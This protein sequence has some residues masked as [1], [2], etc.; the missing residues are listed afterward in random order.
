MR[1]NAHALRIGAMRR[2]PQ[3]GVSRGDRAIVGVHC[4]LAAELLSFE[5]NK[6]MMIRLRCCASCLAMGWLISEPTAASE[7]RSGVDWPQFRGVNACGVSDGAK[8]PT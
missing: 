3:L 1:N 8:S 2:L 7:P 6:P 5:R 4:M